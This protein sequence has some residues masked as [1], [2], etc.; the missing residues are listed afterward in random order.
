LFHFEVGNDYA[1]LIYSGDINIPITNL[2]SPEEYPFVYDKP[3]NVFIF[4]DMTSLVHEQNPH[5][6]FNL[7]L[8]VFEKFNN[9]YTYHHGQDTIERI[10]K[11]SPEMASTSLILQGTSFVVEEKRGV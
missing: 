8:P 1:V 5:T 11:D 3:E 9:L 10:V 2:M 4:H 6:H 7:L